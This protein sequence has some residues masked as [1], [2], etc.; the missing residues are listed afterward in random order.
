LIGSTLLTPGTVFANSLNPA[1]LPRL[2]QAEL[3]LLH[4]G[5][6]G[7]GL[8]SNQLE[9]A[10]NARLH[11]IGQ[12][13]RDFERYGD[14]MIEEDDAFLASIMEDIAERHISDFADYIDQA[15]LVEDYEPD[16][17]DPNGTSLPAKVNLEKGMFL[18][19]VRIRFQRSFAG[20][21]SKASRKAIP[22]ITSTFRTR[23]SITKE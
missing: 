22:A 18:N 23:M 17:E 6:A 5:P 20:R 3:R 12:T 1:N 13:I 19:T 9:I 16:V 2:K 4:E 15:I 7:L 11:E 8:T 21:S 14:D 10:Y